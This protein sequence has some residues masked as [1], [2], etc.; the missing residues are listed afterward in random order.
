M[1]PNLLSGATD[2]R[3]Y[4]SITKHGLYRYSGISLS[5]SEVERVHGIDERV[6]A[7]QHAFQN[8]TISLSGILKVLLSSTSGRFVRLYYLLA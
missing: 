7:S 6:K 1:V 4:S 2:S 8:S 3:H 5:S